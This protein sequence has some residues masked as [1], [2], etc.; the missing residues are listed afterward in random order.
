MGQ[1]V[2]NLVVN[3]AQLNRGSKK[4][5]LKNTSWR[6]CLNWDW[7]DKKFAYLLF[8]RPVTRYCMEPGRGSINRK[9]DDG[10]GK[11]LL[12]IRKNRKC[13]VQST[14]FSLRTW[15]EAEVAWRSWGFNLSNCHVDIFPWFFSGKYWFGDH[16]QYPALTST[17]VLI[18]TENRLS[19]R[20]SGWKT[21]LTYFSQRRGAALEVFSAIPCLG[22]PGALSSILS[23]LQP[24]RNPFKGANRKQLG[25]IRTPRN[26]LEQMLSE[27]H[28]CFDGTR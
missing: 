11:K 6:S 22:P 9:W 27:G 2:A 24:P 26:F 1:T 8:C 25:R 7:E 28:T 3:V 17:A 18:Y 5:R 19:I 21:Y 10:K 14:G 23:L 15:L 16:N 13:C 20:T 12:C 4:Q